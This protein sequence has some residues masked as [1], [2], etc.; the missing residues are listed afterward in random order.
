MAG[1]VVGRICDG[2]GAVLTTPPPAV[3][4]VVEEVAVGTFT[5][6]EG[7]EAEVGV[8]FDFGALLLCQPPPEEEVDDMK[9]ICGK[10]ILCDFTQVSFNCMVDLLNLGDAN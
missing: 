9:I 4:G 1:E 10:A 3:G 2:T 5:P 7:F 6:E 8:Y